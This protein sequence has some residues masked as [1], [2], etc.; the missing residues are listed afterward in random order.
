[1]QNSTS[2]SNTKDR[3]AAPGQS[4]D[5]KRLK[6]GLIGFGTVGRSVAKILCKDAK[7]PL[8]LTHICNRD[9]E[10]KKT[11]G[12]PGDIRWTASADEVL[13]SNVDVIVELIGGLE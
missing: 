7:G 9:I 2:A 10:K 12:L 4:S 1:M 8:V 11:D 5:A 6:V 3:I 13:S